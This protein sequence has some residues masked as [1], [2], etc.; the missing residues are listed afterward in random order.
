MVT[1][2]REGG[3]RIV[4][5]PDDHWPPHVHVY[6]DGEARITVLTD[7]VDVLSSSGMTRADVSKARRLV[8]RHRLELIATWRRY[9]G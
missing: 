9:H 4:I 5:Y 2:I 8:G 7:P 6:G 3:F 1:V